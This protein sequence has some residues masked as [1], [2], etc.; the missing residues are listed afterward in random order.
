MQIPF[1]ERIPVIQNE[2]NKRRAKYTLSTLD[3]EDVSQIII[4]R[5]YNKYHL[6]KSEK[7]EFTHWLNRLIS[8]AMKNILRDNLT[9]FSRPCI[10]GCAYNMGEDNCGYTTTGKQCS[11]CPI[12]KRWE[13][14]KKD[15]FNVKQ[16]LTIENHSQEVSNMASDFFDIEHA[17]KIIDQKI[18]TKLNAFEFSIYEMLYIQNMTEKQVGEKLKYKKP[19]NSSTPGY[20]TI[21]KLKRKFA[22]ISREI[23]REEDLG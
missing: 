23:I 14:K 12:F 1:E 4:L 10:L 8:S 16:T 6:Y 17:K 13:K 3:F 11:E 22:S 19:T 7:G 18:K 20:Q 9:I 2:I 21:S 15:H 5:V